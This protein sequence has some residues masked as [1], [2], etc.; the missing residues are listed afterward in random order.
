MA[1]MLYYP[2]AN[3]PRSVLQRAILYWDNL[4]TVVA[5]GWEARLSAWMREVQDAGLYRPLEANRAFGPYA[6]HEIEGELERVLRRIPTDDLLPPTAPPSGEFS[7]LHVE[8]LHGS[9]VDELLQRQL[10]YPHPDS[11]SRLVA[12]PA[13]LNVVVSLIAGRIAAE[14]NDR[15]GCIGPEGLRPYT[16]HEVAHRLGTEPL[17][18]YDVTACWHVDVGSL[19]P[20]PSSDIRINDLV[21]F[22]EEYD[23][24]RQRLMFAIDE[25]LHRLKQAGRHPQD[26]FS[27]VEKELSEA[28]TDVRAAAQ[29]RKLNLVARPLAVTVAIGAAGIGAIAEP[30]LAVPMGVLSSI[31][32]N[33]ATG[34]IRRAGNDSRKLADFKYLH[35]VKEAVGGAA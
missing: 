32:V 16:D 33:M 17:S 20:V 18:D 13:L 22:R 14:H 15:S 29:G 7:T 4:A 31:V 10:V 3:A 25:M 19:L 8:K 23:D 11:P 12:A 1:G 6:L 24:E 35:R 5:P 30:A 27:L 9:V 21:R 34:R 28:L 2:F 26:A